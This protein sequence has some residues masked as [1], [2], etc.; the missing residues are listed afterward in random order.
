MLRV[1]WYSVGLNITSIATSFGDFAVI[2]RIVAFCT[3]A[4][5]QQAARRCDGIGGAGD[6]ADRD[7]RQ[8]LVRELHRLDRDGV[9]L[10]IERRAGDLLRERVVDVPGGQ[11][12]PQEA[13]GL[14]GV[15]P[16]AL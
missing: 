14:R 5:S 4:S 2:M 7:P 8:P 3:S 16:V 1:I 12:D 11:R 13:G 9:A 15:E 10:G 6:H